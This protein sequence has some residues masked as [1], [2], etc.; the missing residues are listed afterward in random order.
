M[1]RVLTT[2]SRNTQ[3]GHTNMNSALGGW[4]PRAAEICRRGLKG[5]GISARA[6]EPVGASVSTKVAELRGGQCISQSG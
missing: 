4:S 5:V 6:A 2:H 3:T 1:I